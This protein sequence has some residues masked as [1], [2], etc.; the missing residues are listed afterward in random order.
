MFKLKE[1]NWA[2]I[3]ILF[4]VM[5]IAAYIAQ[6]TTEETTETTDDE[7]GS[8]SVTK[9]RISFLPEKEDK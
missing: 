9:R 3:M 4:V 2:Y 7:E 1:I 6:V 5:V 8:V